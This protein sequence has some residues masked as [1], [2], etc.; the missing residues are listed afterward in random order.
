MRRLLRKRREGR[1]CRRTRRLCCSPC[2]AGVEA[3]NGRG[4]A[5]TRRSRALVSVAGSKDAIRLCS[6]TSM[7]ILCAILTGGGRA[8]APG[9]PPGN[10]SRPLVRLGERMR[11]G[12]RAADQAAPR[13][14]MIRVLFGAGDGGRG[15]ISSHRRLRGRC[16]AGAGGTRGE[17]RRFEGRGGRACLGRFRPERP[18]AAGC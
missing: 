17:G 5:T 2:C 13:P 18:L 16:V 14:P 9:R 7:M 4:P 8:E 10:T 3:A 1:G 11:A 12:S 6:A 15:A